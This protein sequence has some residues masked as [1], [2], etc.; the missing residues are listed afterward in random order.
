V[1][2]LALDARIS[3]WGW[4][5]KDQ[6]RGGSSGSQG[7]TNPGERDLIICD[8]NGD[9]L[10]VCEAFIWSNFKIAQAHI[11]KNFNYTH[12]RKNFIILIYDKRLYRNF[13]KNWNNYKNTTLPKIKYPLGFDLKKSK[14]KELTGRFGH[15]SSGIKV[16]CSKHGKDTKIFHIM[17]N[18]NYRIK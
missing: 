13:D 18:L 8:S 2:Q 6:S 7:S 4:Q 10:I 3:Q 5:I 14:W 1:V 17:V 11:I 9:I 12:K 15:K 16:G